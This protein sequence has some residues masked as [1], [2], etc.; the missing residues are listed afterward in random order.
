MNDLTTEELQTLQAEANST[1]DAII[2]S[3]EHSVGLQSAIR[4]IMQAD[5]FEVP[6][7]ERLIASEPAVANQV[8]FSAVGALVN[9]QALRA[10][11]A[12]LARRAA[13]N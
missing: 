7:F 8:L 5:G 4:D 9:L 12:E 2:G 13:G 3:I 6:T 1:L 10:V 11:K